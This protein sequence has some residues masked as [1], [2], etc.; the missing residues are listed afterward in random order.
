MKHGSGLQSRLVTSGLSVDEQR[1]MK[2][3][4]NQG[5]VAFKPFL[6]EPEKQKRYEEFLECKKQGVKCKKILKLSFNFTH[7]ETV[8]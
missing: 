6:N 5:F 4:L 8:F 3:P 7:H 1:K 2:V